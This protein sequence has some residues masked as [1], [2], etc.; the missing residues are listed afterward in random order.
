[1]KKRILILLLVVCASFFSSIAKPSIEFNLML[2]KVGST[3]LNF[4][5]KDG[6]EITSIDNLISTDNVSPVEDII[7]YVDYVVSNDIMNFVSDLFKVLLTFSASGNLNNESD[8]ML[9]HSTEPNTGL[10]FDY[11]VY[12]STNEESTN[13]ESTSE[14]ILKEK[15]FLDEKGNISKKIGLDV[16]QI[17]L[18]SR[19]EN[20]SLP[21]TGH[22]KV[23]LSIN[24]PLS[25]DETGN[26]IEAF[27]S[28]QYVGYVILSI[29]GI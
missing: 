20:D 1:M 7:F 16:R 5:S 10:V 19:T 14:E 2:R 17:E 6:A 3:S 15:S 9:S 27:T 8:W 21:V 23:S 11:H 24:P 12:K 18:F 29:V 25:T 13:E 26:T 22:H 28:G 4:Y